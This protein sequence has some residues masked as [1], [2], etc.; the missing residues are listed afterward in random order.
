MPRWVSS[1][2]LWNGAKEPLTQKQ[3]KGRQTMIRQTMTR[4]TL[5]ALSGGAI[6]ALGAISRKTSPED[7]RFLEDLSRR[8]FQFF[9]EHSDPDTGLTR[10]RALTDGAPCDN[11]RR[12]IG[13]LAAV[14][15]GFSATC[16][17]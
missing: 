14:G 4:R 7:E 10:D 15:F 2:P 11:T 3:I 5:L 17:C 6:T 8:G 1:T 12:D 13:R 9:W 16:I